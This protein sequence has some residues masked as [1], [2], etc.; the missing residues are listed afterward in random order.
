VEKK[1]SFSG[2]FPFGH[3][4]RNLYFGHRGHS[5]LVSIVTTE[6]EH[7]YRTCFSPEAK[8][9]SHKWYESKKETKYHLKMS[10][11]VLQRLTETVLISYFIS[12]E[13]AHHN[14]LSCFYVGVYLCFAYLRV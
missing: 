8:C 5:P 2:H 12:T 6:W 13:H 9:T 3:F 7:E 11:T 1:L 10:G 4:P 14:M